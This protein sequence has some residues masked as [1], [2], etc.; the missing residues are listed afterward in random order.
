MNLR[1]RC[2][3][4]AANTGRA[5]E[6][7][8]EKMSQPV[9]GIKKE[10]TPMWIALQVYVYATFAQLRLKLLDRCLENV[11]ANV[12]LTCDDCIMDVRI[13]QLVWMTRAL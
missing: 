12:R 11:C 13:T 9:L 1:A 5:H 6:N 10:V 8:E 3:C 2:A 7:G 4:S